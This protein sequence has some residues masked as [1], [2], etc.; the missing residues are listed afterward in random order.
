MEK[1]P[2]GRS[3]N[4]VVKIQCESQE[5]LDPLTENGFQ[6]GFQMRLEQWNQCVVQDDYLNLSTQVLTLSYFSANLAPPL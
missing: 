2:K 5:I 4:T 3:F 1:Q 6:T